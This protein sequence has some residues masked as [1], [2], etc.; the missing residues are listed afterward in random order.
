MDTFTEHQIR[1]F[2]PIILFHDHPFSFSP[3]SP[4]DQRHSYYS[5]N[6]N[7][8]NDQFLPYSSKINNGMDHHLETHKQRINDMLKVNNKRRRGNLPKPV[9]AILKKWLLEHCRNP[10]PTEEEKLQ[11]KSETHLTLNQISNWFI[12]ARRR[13]L[14]VILAK[15]NHHYP[16]I[17]ARRRRR[18]RQRQDKNI[19]DLTEA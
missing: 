3:S 11:L 19:S 14:P 1:L 13:T 4:Q 17:K 9:T 18:R 5:S 6:N 2:R 12:N 7:L 16:G 8:C 15:L 10:Y